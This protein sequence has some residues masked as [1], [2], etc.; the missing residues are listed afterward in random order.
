MTEPDTTDVYEICWIRGEG[1]QG[2]FTIEA[3]QV[4]YPDDP[5]L[6][7]YRFHAH[8]DGALKTVLHIDAR[9]VAYVRLATNTTPPTPS[10]A[11]EVRTSI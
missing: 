8:V 1:I 10:R 6:P 4:D 9:R 2:A 11:S 3:S 7:A 5:E